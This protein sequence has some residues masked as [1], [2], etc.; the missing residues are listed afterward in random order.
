MHLHIDLSEV[1]YTCKLGILIGAVFFIGKSAAGQGARYLIDNTDHASDVVFQPV[2]RAAYKELSDDAVLFT[3]Q[4][5]V[6]R[7]RGQLISAKK[8]FLFADLGQM[9][10]ALYQGGELVK[11]FEIKAKGKEGTFF[12]TPSG[13]YKV[14]L[15]EKKHFSSIGSVWMPWSMHFFG[16]YFIH[17][18]PYYPNGSPVPEGFSGGCIR[19]ATEDAKELFTLTRQAIPV[20]TYSGH[21]DKDFAQASYFQKVASASGKP[22]PL[23]KVSAPALLAVDF[24]TGQILYEKN[25]DVS[26]PI[27]SITKLMTGLVAVE[28]INRFKVLAMTKDASAT[29]GD[30]AE[31]KSG[32]EFKAEDFLY[33]LILASS[34]DVAALYAGEV[35][36]FVRI[37]NEKA[38]GIGMSS[39]HFADAIGLSPENVSTPA[40]IFKLLHF[41]SVHKKPLFAVASFKEYTLTS[42][43]E[44]RRTHTWTRVNWPLDDERFVA[45]KVGLSDEALE[46]MA[47]VWRVRVSEQ[48]TRPVAVI[49]LGSQD[50]KKD[51]EAVLEY[52]EEGFVYG[53]VFAKEKRKPIVIKSGA[54]IFEAVEGLFDRN[55]LPY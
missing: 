51:V 2:E 27:A 36:G 42:L 52:L 35:W 7:E 23:P 26:F 3:S 5:A 24:E 40:D 43:D 14:Q 1:W 48:G 44:K 13:L 46:T 33:P 49:V 11:E 37:M 31:L 32:E 53:N 29:Y 38:R 6:L 50:R 39:T 45:G 18:W 15:K 21:S 20:L 28:T 19:L 47:G 25:K 34:N 4:E 55:L 12:E 9:T 41:I 54:S 30:S 22:V 10:I 17:G 8:D 16:N